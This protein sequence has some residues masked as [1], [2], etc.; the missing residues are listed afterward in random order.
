MPGPPPPPPY[1]KEQIGA[2]Q[3]ESEKKRAIAEIQSYIARI[4]REQGGQSTSRDRSQNSHYHSG[5]FN[6]NRH[7]P[8][9]NA[10]P[11]FRNKTVTFNNNTHLITFASPAQKTTEDSGAVMVKE[12]PTK[13][14][15]DL[16]SDARDQPRRQ[17]IQPKKLCSA[18]T[19]TGIQ[20]KDIFTSVTPLCV[21]STDIIPGLCTRPRCSLIHDP[22][23]LAVCKAWLY[24]GDCSNG[25]F[26][27][28]SHEPSLH[29]APTCLHFQ[30]GRCNN[31]RCR[32]AHIR[33]NPAALNC[34]AFGFT[35]YCEKGAECAERHAHECPSFSNTGYCT[36][37][38]KCRLPHVH[39]A[40]R[41]KNTSGRNSEERVS[42]TNGQENSA[43]ATRPRNSKDD[44]TDS[45]GA[46]TPHDFTQQVDFVP[47]VRDE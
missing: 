28:L 10:T 1:T 36:F 8:Y 29:N 3:T 42:P 19:R 23:K 17:Q 7:H 45:D 24:K 22:N 18:F 46:P 30:D 34:E 5:A 25:S 9:Q 11:R 13:E 14:T 37:G 6:S 32:F 38:D 4:E 21:R 47:L 43:S 26:C 27:Y 31:E 12:V 44:G 41:M 40:S 20:Q 33:I 35:G 2:L 16:A 39:R 15:S